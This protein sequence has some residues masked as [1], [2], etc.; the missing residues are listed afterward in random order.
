MAEAQ[1]KLAKGKRARPSKMKRAR[2]DDIGEEAIVQKKPRVDKK[3]TDKAANILLQ[4]TNDVS[5]EMC[6]SKGKGEVTLKIH[7]GE[8]KIIIPPHIWK[9]LHLSSEAI[10][11]LLSFIEGPGGISDYY[12]SYY[13]NMSAQTNGT[14]TGNTD[15]VQ[16]SHGEPDRDSSKVKDT[17]FQKVK[18]NDLQVTLT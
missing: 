13:Y 15:A 6:K 4:L 16:R 18:D 3:P 10:S 17:E 12:Q 14:Q 8:K 11:L 1:V 7:H 5:L 2:E 9:I